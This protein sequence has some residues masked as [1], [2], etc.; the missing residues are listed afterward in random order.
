MDPQATW[1]ELLSCY[2]HAQFDE[3]TVA[4]ENLLQWLQCG[5]FP[6]ITNPLIA[7]GDELHRV[8]A[9]AVVQHVLASRQ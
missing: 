5:G 3:A 1:D 7:S 4:A 8:I 6:P 9:R 2:R